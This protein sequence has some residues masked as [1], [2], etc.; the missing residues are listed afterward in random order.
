MVRVALFVDPETTQV[1]AVSDPIPDVFGGA[2]LSIRQIELNLNRKE[3][4]LN[5]TSCAKLQSTATLNGGG[6]NPASS[7]AWSSFGA[8]A[9]F[10]TSG[11]EA[12]EFQPQLTIRFL[13]GR[14]ATKRTGHP[15]L[16]ATLEA[17]EGDAN[18]AAATVTL[19]RS[20]LLD[21]SHIK[22][23][24]TRV[25]LAAQQCPAAS[26]YG[27]ASAESPLLE[28]ELAGPVYLVSSDHTLPDLLADLQGQ[29]D[30]R[31]HGVIKSVAPRPHPDQ[32][33][34]DPRRAGEQIHPD[35]GRR[36]EGPPGQLQRRLR[37]SATSRGS[38]SRRRT[39]SSR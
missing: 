10:Q 38:N 15:T 7:S 16:Q 31:L 8:T 28:K 20:E 21:Q 1:T 27:H 33:R 30:V 4:T 36:Q 23:I 34:A 17:R 22:T 5:P 18:I 39:A 19:P 29:V 35:H 14:K 32:L 3:F 9:P 11:C 12:L 2:Q 6:G 13:G 26:V 37:A 24:C 25:Q